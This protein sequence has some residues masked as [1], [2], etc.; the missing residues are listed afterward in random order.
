VALS[1]FSRR[2][3]AIARKPNE[4][5]WRTGFTKRDKWAGKRRSIYDVDSA[6]WGCRLAV[7]EGEV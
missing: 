5:R 6:L 4:V 2:K 7:E 3:G 1:E